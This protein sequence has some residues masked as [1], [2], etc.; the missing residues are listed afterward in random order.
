[1]TTEGT[2][3][4]DVLFE[5]GNFRL[6]AERAALLRD[7]DEVH[8]RPKSF[9][10]LEYLVR[11][12]GR[13]VTRRELMDAVWGPAVVTDDSLTQC[14]IDIRRALGDEG[15]QAVRTVPRR[16]FVFELPVA[17][18]RRDRPAGG[19]GEDG[20][21]PAG[22]AP[23]AAPHA[24]P[25][26]RAS[27]PTWTIPVI[28]G[29]AVVLGLLAWWMPG[30]V[31]DTVD[32]P[33]PEGMGAAPGNSIA[34]LRFADLSQAGDKQYFA[35]GL[36]EEVLHRL[37]QSPDLVVIARSSSFSLDSAGTDVREAGARLGVAYVLEG[38][39]RRDGD[40]LRVTAQLIDAGTG[41]HVW[42]KRFEGRSSD[43]MALQDDIADSVARSL[44]ASL[45]AREADAAAAADPAAQEL[46]LQGLFVY[47]RRGPGDVALARDYFERAL[48]I[49]P[50]HARALTAL[51]G[52]LR[53]QAFDGEMEW[54]ESFATQRA[55]LTRALAA[56]PGLAEAHLRLSNVQYALGD[57][58]AAEESFRRA[59]ELDPDN[60][61]ALSMR[62]GRALAAGR[63]DEAVEFSGQVVRRDPVSAVSVFNHG[64]TLFAAGRLE[65][66]EAVLRRANDLQ[67]GERFEMDIAKIRVLQ[68]RFGDAVELARDAPPGP[69]RDLV[70]AMA[71]PVAG[72]PEEA[73]AALDG[74]RA[75][76][77]R[78]SFARLAEVLAF[79][80]HLDEAFAALDRAVAGS[81]G[82]PRRVDIR[83]E[84]AA[85]WQRTV[86]IIRVSP[87]LAPLRS[88]PRWPAYADV[89]W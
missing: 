21:P 5:F 76:G 19:Q 44:H 80:G 7:G 25:P 15:Q 40:D 83:Q 72:T 57:V 12:P 16:G 49:Q 30:R 58:D 6:D 45:A 62:A 50:D 4:K 69:D 17:T 11:N 47:N 85:D 46:F 73:A 82:R 86:D 75:A 14:L 51:A 55:M 60:L 28:L 65:E 77:T 52:A 71:A 24:V 84:H 88:D 89:A 35:D 43:P 81:H 22:P 1:V 3:R 59:L 74:L 33:R 53:V 68:A 29:F 31:V 36:A 67:P 63:L 66:A 32:T 70:L 41:A 56:N 42:S 61:L 26:D 23:S 64:Q 37:A 78:T 2:T 8:L 18:A 39:V 20:P 13:L 48:A 54:D 79:R 10:V 38:S 9:Q 27:R 34:V 87:F